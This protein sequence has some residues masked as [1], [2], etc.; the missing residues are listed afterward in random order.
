MIEVTRLAWK[1]SR[2]RESFPCFIH[3]C[4]HQARH[5]VKLRHGKVI[6]QVCLCDACMRKSVE[7]I[8]LGLGIRSQERVNRSIGNSLFGEAFQD[9]RPCDAA[10]LKAPRMRTRQDIAPA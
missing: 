7:M 3:N 1:T 9:G 2:H 8:L 5:V 10:L 6:V 4:R